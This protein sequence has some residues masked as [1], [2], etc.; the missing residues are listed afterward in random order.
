MTN[1]A[2]LWNDLVNLFFPRL[3]KICGKPLIKG[4]EQ[5]CL[6]CLCDLPQTRYHLLTKD[7]PVELLFAGRVPIRH[8]TSF[9]HYEKK[10]SVQKLIHSLKY[11]DNKELG[12]LLGRMAAKE[13]QMADHPICQVDF[14]IP[15]PLHPQKEK[16][17]GY[18]QSEWIAQGIQSVWNCPVLSTVLR[19]TS[20]TE[21]QTHKSG[22]E[23]W[24]NV[25]SVFQAARPSELE[26]KHILI[27]DD[28]IT[29]GS[30]IGACAEALLDIPD[31]Q[32]SL[33]SLAIA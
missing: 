12:F 26:G 9:L 17:R 2:N 15:V 18:N 13:L 5:I 28:V 7:N 19:R 3:C 8:A 25:R 24:N 21:S 10:S 29:T 23:R 20:S 30:T 33:F 27:I 1:I 16:K 6:H 4:E 22:F 14:L 31:I 11:Y 32:I